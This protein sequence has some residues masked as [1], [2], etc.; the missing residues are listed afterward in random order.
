MSTPKLNA[1][2]KEMAALT[3]L[4]KSLYG[5]KPDMG[6][7]ASDETG[8][9][10][11]KPLKKQSAASYIREQKNAAQAAGQARPNSRDLLKQYKTMMTPIKT[12]PIEMAGRDRPVPV[13]MGESSAGGGPRGGLSPYN[14][15]PVR[16]AGS[17]MSGGMGGGRPVPS[18]GGGT[19]AG[20]LSPR[21]AVTGGAR[22]APS[23]GG[24]MP[25][26]TGMPTSAPPPGAM[27]KK[28]G[29]VRAEKMASGGMTSKAPTASK[30]GDGIAQRGKTKGRMV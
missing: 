10:F 1:T 20:T 9:S 7:P 27:F 15:D 28:G 13:G 23:M 26:A 21:G 18:M 14:T 4:N 12:M 5:T 6:V 19:P 24:G 16:P 29:S 11:S 3:K 25:G 8:I 2:S 22:P 30:R 17:D